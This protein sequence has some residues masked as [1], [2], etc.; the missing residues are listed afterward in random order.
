MLAGT[1][2]R[3]DQ[4]SQ[5]RLVSLVPCR[6]VIIFKSFGMGV[7]PQRKTSFPC[8][9]A[10]RAGERHNNM[11]L[12]LILLTIFWRAVH[13]MFAQ[14][15][16]VRNSTSGL[17]A[18]FDASTT[19]PLTLT[20]N[21]VSAG[22]MLVVQIENSGSS[23]VQVTDNLNSGVYRTA[24][25]ASSS[26]IGVSGGVTTTSYMPNS[27]AGNVTI[28]ITQSSAT[29]LAGW[30]YDVSGP[31]VLGPTLANNKM[32]NLNP[33]TISLLRHVLSLIRF[34][35]F[36]PTGS[37]TTSGSISVN[38]GDFVIGG[39]TVEGTVTAGESGWTGVL[40]GGDATQYL[41]PAS[42]GSVASTTTY[43][44]GQGYAATIASFTSSANTVSHP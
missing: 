24:V 8:G 39:T 9:S 4:G 17:S 14:D 27:V 16:A 37:P 29:Y 13:Q 25:S 43:T 32:N 31:K 11:K 2:K 7:N 15:T 20:M 42:A 33:M 18:S 36:A 6:P 22:D 34:F 12:T 3:Y 35:S 41:I 38:A 1:V 40:Q 21:G 5:H 19:T 28:T 30:A 10:V 23:S 44:P 26:S